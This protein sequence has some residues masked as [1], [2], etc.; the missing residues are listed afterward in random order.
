MIAFIAHFFDKKTMK[1]HLLNYISVCIFCFNRVWHV[2]A[3][4]VGLWPLH[5]AAAKPTARSDQLLWAMNHALQAAA[6]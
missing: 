2:R 3:A 1:Y 5:S 6:Q 4:V